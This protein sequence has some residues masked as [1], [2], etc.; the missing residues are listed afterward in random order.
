MLQFLILLTLAGI[1]AGQKSSQEAAIISESRYLNTAGQFGSSYTQEDGVEF[2][3]EAD[4]EGNRKGSYTYIDPNGHRKTITY[5]AGKDGFQAQGDHIPVPPAPLPVNSFPS[6]AQLPLPVNYQ[7]QQVS[8]AAAVPPQPNSLQVQFQ[9]YPAPGS[10]LL[11]LFQLQP[12]PLISSTENPITAR[13]YPP[14]K[15]NVKQTPD[16]FSYTFNSIV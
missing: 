10:P 9:S 8:P 2:K 11:N 4:S 15:L 6:I 1:I 16:G 5:T 7:V 14:A 12:L 3:E 13:Q